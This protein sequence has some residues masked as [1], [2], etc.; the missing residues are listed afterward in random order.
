MMQ[1]VKMLLS[2]NPWTSC[3]GIQC[4][5]LHCIALILVTRKSLLGTSVWNLDS[6]S[7][8]DNAI[9]PSRERHSAHSQGWSE[10]RT[11]AL[12]KSL[13]LQG[14]EAC[15]VQREAI[16]LGYFLPNH[17][18]IAQPRARTAAELCQEKHLSSG[19]KHLS[20]YLWPYKEAALNTHFRMG[21][22][23]LRQNLVQLPNLIWL[24]WAWEWYKDPVFKKLLS[25]LEQTAAG[26]AANG[27]REL[28]A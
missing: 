5:L 18:A 8:N 28:M 11:S 6:V 9:F 7:H 22:I 13:I 21:S 17:R 23:R 20:E 4:N 26:F 2:T 3:C 25:A 15:G 10:H 16:T 19:R 1:I 12:W 14:L 24:G 27:M